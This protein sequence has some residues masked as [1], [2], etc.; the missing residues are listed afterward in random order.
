MLKFGLITN[1][2][3]FLLK[4]R[5]GVKMEEEIEQKLGLGYKMLRQLAIEYFGQKG[6]KN[7]RKERGENK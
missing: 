4:L 2:R 1:S 5:R 3:L 6:E 7:E